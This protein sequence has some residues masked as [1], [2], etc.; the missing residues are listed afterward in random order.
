MSVF[1]VLLWP[2]R[3]RGR[4]AAAPA[5]PTALP[6]LT[7]EQYERL[8]PAQQLREGNIDVI[9]ATPNMATKWRVDSLFTKEPDTIEW[10]RGFRP[11]EILV[12]IGA[13]VGMYTIWAAKT[14]GVK[15]YAFEPESQNY[16]LLYKNIVLNG[17]AQ[18]VVAYCVA[19]SDE[20]G[21]SLLH[22]SAFHLGGSCHTFGEKV[23]YKLERR[24]SK[25]SQGCVSTTLDQL[26]E[27]GVV[28]PPDHI[29]IDVD[30]FEHK[31]LAGCRHVLTNP[32]LKSILVEINTNLEQHR[33]IIT[34]LKELGF[35]YSEQQAATA[36]RTEGAF[37]GVGNH[38]F[39]R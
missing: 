1:R 13:N 23:D 32:R 39:R 30:G 14:R 29:K 20:S 5:V 7:L 24:E 22:L 12:D 27:S 4:P 15:V 28:A 11:G 17:L 25:V 6:A 38:V 16:A 10:I 26:I 31:V 33:K 9:Y 21:Y 35:T 8:A 18:Q 36:L 34:D 19:L 37:E 3:H 2:F